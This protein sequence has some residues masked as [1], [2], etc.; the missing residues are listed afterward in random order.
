[1]NNQIFFSDPSCPILTCVEFRPLLQ[2]LHLA[3]EREC[4]SKWVQ[5]FFEYR[6][7]G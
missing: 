4:L 7:S 1:M 3:V 2:M 6:E 5:S